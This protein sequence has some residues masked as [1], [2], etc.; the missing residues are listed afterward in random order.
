MACF[1]SFFIF[2][3]GFILGWHRVACQRF[4]NITVDDGDAAI[5]YTGSWE[6]SAVSELDVGGRHMIAVH[7]DASA[8]FV[9][10]GTSILFFCHFFQ[11]NREKTRRCYILL[12]SIMAIQCDHPG[13]IRFGT[14]NDPQ[15]TRR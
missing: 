2:L 3:F 1:S 10:Q 11:T 8:V 4:S 5:S 6:L 12:I 15:F 14:A 7:P 13:P 9:F